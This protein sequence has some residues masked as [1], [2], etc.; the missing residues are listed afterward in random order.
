MS[1]ESGQV[2]A[3]RYAIAEL[4]G[5]GGMG[6]L[7]RARDQQLKRDVVIKIVSP[8]LVGNDAFMAALER[9][10]AIHGSIGNSPSV[11]TLFDRVS[12][13]RLGTLLVMEY[14]AG[15]TLTDWLAVQRLSA[16]AKTKKA[17]FDGILDCLDVVHSQQIVH[18]DLKPDNLMITDEGERLSVKLIDFGV[19]AQTLDLQ[20]SDSSTRSTSMAM[21]GTPSYSA[22]E[23]ID[24]RKWGAP[25]PATDLYAAGAIFYE[26]IFGEPPFSGTNTEILSGH[27]TA[28]PEHLEGPSAIPD[29]LLRVLRRAL[30]KSPMDRYSNVDAFRAAIGDWQNALDVSSNTGG[31]LAGKKETVVINSTRSGRPIVVAAIAALA[32]VGAAAAFLLVG[33]SADDE[34][35]AVVSES[36]D[37]DKSAVDSQAEDENPGGA[38]VVTIVDSANPEITEH[39]LLPPTPVDTPIAVSTRVSR[40]EVNESEDL[41]LLFDQRRLGGGA[42]DGSDHSAGASAALPTNSRA[43]STQRRPAVTASKPRTVSQPKP[44]QRSNPVRTTSSNRNRTAPSANSAN[45]RAGTECGM[46]CGQTKTRQLP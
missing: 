7:Y 12:D 13:D 19:A 41:T 3:K 25:T 33:P 43:P 45:S 29:S 23:L 16:S 24:S 5:K 18:C 34:P 40:N 36:N 30:S 20:G 17:L 32:F 44:Q 14:S 46:S 42:S 2:I 9:E 28:I 10:C 1:L 22:P 39:R 8:S 38:D 11:I 6:E 15:V 21:H 31:Q 4:I 35:P 37:T 26:T 27:L